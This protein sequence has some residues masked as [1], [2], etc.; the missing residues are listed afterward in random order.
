MLV[1]GR[2]VSTII[3]A[4]ARL[5]RCPTSA[6]Q[7]PFLSWVDFFFGSHMGMAASHRGRLRAVRAY[8]STDFYT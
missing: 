2:V 7:G 1:S 8:K 3:I 4:F 5:H 6:R